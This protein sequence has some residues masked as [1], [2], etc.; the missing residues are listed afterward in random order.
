M[1]K[2]LSFHWEPDQKR[3]FAELKEAFTMAPVLAY[4]NYKNTI[5]LEMDASSYISTGVL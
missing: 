5:V 2:L 1:K 4:F 3:A